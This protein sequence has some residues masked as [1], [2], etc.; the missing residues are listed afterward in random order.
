MTD[1]SPLVVLITGAS[2][3]IG[4]ACAEHLHVLGHHVYG[5]SR[6]PQ[7]HPGLP[8]ELIKVD[9][10]DDRSVERGVKLVLDREGRIDV[11][12]NNA[13]G[14]FAGAVEETTIAEAKAQMESGFFGVMRVCR[15]VLPGM[16]MRRSG[17]IVNISSIAGLMGIPFQGVYSASKFALEGLSEALR[18][19]VR[20]SGIRVV[21]VEPGDLRTS[22]TANRRRVKAWTADSPYAARAQKA[23]SVM[24]HDEQSGPPPEIVARLVARIIRANNPR[25]RWVTGPAYEVI[26]P[27]LKRLAP[28]WLFEWGFSKYYGL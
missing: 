16:R 27:A 13:G 20:P 8:F 28:A 21:L 5:T 18:I 12:I 25:L 14:A 23:L 7:D 4:R 15:A 22:F 2:S 10:D 9:V 19:E 11:A 6:R 17:L 3:G 24:E 26:V 1:Q